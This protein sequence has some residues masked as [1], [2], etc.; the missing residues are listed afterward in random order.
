MNR[1]SSSYPS[2][3]SSAALTTQEKILRAARSEFSLW[4]LTGA[5]VDRIAR[6]A[7][8]NKAMIYYHYSSKKNLYREVLQSHFRKV[9]G[10]LK[11]RLSGLGTVEARLEAAA[12]VWAEVFAEMPDFRALIMRELAR[13]TPELLDQIAVVLVSTDLPRM[14]P[15]MMSG[16]IAAGR[17]RD[18]DTRQALVSFV[19]M[20]IGYFFISPLIDRVLRIGNKE[21]FV[22]NRKQAVVDIFLYGVKAR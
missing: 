14:I 1:Y 22:K 21:D 5:R 20:N 17:F 12:E 11:N 8:V 7:G 3:S 18:V 19:T 4:G 9:G 15:Q 2:D 6:N 10:L 16:E 13:P